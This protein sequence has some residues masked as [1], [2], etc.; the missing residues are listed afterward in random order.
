M[1]D[2]REIWYD[3]FS[4]FGAL[5][6]LLSATALSN[7]NHKLIRDVNGRHLENFN[8]VLTTPPMVRFI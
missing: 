6:D 4:K 2:R 7:W 3:I 1:T 8:D 5:R